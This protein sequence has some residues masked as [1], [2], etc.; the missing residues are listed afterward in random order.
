MM[1]PRRSVLYVPG[2]NARAMEKAHSL[3]S[4]A[5]VF[6]L[7]DSVAPDAKAA[8]RAQVA[9][10][11]AVHDFR[12]REVIIRVNGLDTPWWID[13]INMVAK[14]KPDAILVPKIE[15]PQHLSDIA[16][17]LSDIGADHSIRVWVMVETARAILT[18]REIAATAKDPEVRLAGFVIGTN[19]VAKE[20]R[21]RLLP[22]RANMLPWLSLCV[23]SARAYGLE[24]LDGV[25]N[26]ISDEAG[27]AAECAQARDLGFDGK[28]LIH[29]NQIGP[30]NDAFTP[31]ADE[32]AQARN[33]IAAFD[34]PENAGKGAIQLD[35]KM[36]ERLHAD[37][38]KR[39]VAI[40]DAIAARG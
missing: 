32:V 15:T 6:D 19:D 8:A 21:M 30:C 1:K 13:D 23:L 40:A 9:K 36:V 24:I 20:T 35:G 31:P 34:L 11:V 18:L 33:I 38:A 12:P 26:D 39:T 5:V 16:D 22:G 25:Y 4:D 2:S 27:F 29:P 17:R 37:M 3:T 28:T 10:A 7:E 14:A